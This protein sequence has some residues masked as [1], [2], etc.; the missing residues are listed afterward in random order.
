[1]FLITLRPIAMKFRHRP[2][3]VAM[4]EPNLLWSK[5]KPLKFSRN[6][7]LE[8]TLRNWNESNWVQVWSMILRGNVLFSPKKLYIHFGDLQEVQKQRFGLWVSFDPLKTVSGTPTVSVFLCQRSEMLQWGWATQIN[9]LWHERAL[10]C[11]F[12]WPQK[13]S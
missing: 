5:L 7:Q 10:S 9:H 3:L 1:M 12:I 8:R 11:Q 2:H 6:E 13:N 4:C